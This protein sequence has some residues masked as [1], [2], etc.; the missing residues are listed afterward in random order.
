MF[1]NSS[2]D[3][4]EYTTSVIGFVPTVTV[5]TDPTQ[6]PWITGR[7]CTE[8]KAR[9]ATFKERDTYLYPYKKSHYEPSNRQSVNT[10]LRLNPTLML[11]RCG[12]LAITDY[13]RKPSRE[14]T[15]EASLPDKLNNA[16]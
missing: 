8:L 12:R 3:T 15:S 13:K 14:L 4:E 10:G 16:F 9:A 11:V 2:Y 5:R 1:R 6:K 7:I